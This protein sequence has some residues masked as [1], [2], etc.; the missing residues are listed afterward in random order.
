MY[1]ELRRAFGGVN[2]P[3]VVMRRIAA[4]ALRLI[5][6]AN[7]SVVELAN[8]NELVCV[9]GAGSMAEPAGV[10]VR[11][12]ASL[13]GLA[14]RT[15]ATL[16]GDD[17]ETDPRVDR[18]ACRRFGS[19]S[20][21]CV[22]LRRGNTTVGVFS[23]VSSSPRAFND[24]DVA[25]LTGLAEFI[26]TTITMTS[27][28]HKIADEL[29]N[30]STVQ[31]GPDAGAMSTFVANVLTPGVA[32]EVELAQRVGRVIAA[33][34]FTVVFQPVVDLRTEQLVGTEALTRFLPGPYRPPNEWFAE[35]HRVG[36]GVELEHAAVTA[37]LRCANL[38]PAETYIAINVGPEALQS[39]EMPTILDSF[40]PR[41]IVIE[42][43]EHVE[44]N[45]YP[46]L[47]RTLM[48]IRECGVRLAIDDTGAGISSLSHIVKLAPDIIKVDR[49]F[50]QGID[51]DP[52][53]RSLVAAVVAF[54]PELGATI[55]AEGIETEAELVTAREL[56][57]DCG[58][59]YFLGR[60]GP[61]EMLQQHAIHALGETT[62]V[63]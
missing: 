3:M 12:D 28:L 37:A 1:D 14:F 11:V 34:A 9:C 35:A 16:R 4:E 38:L 39:P 52:V 44:I 7:G 57:V 29:I 23:V 31:S 2:D 63:A 32:D 42:L 56:K 54:A 60:P 48:S 33:H 58:Q 21:V 13:S 8:G 17:S 49:D 24:R 30:T 15:G 6:R 19:I 10:R 55:V 46:Q 18:D 51:F 59:G 45:D 61:V 25:T 40:D 43:T 47:R 26:T 62:I 27:E 36:R 41:R 5:P 50:I 22:P 53:R 20:A